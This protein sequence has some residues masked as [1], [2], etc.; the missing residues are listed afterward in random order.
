M[1]SFLAPLLSSDNNFC[2]EDYRADHDYCRVTIRLSWPAARR[3]VTLFAP[4]LHSVQSSVDLRTA[5]EIERERVR[6]RE[7]R[8]YRARQRE[9]RIIALRAL[10]CV[11]RDMIDYYQFSQMTEEGH[12]NGYRHSIFTS[13]SE[14]HFLYHEARRRCLLNLKKKGLSHS[15]IAKRLGMTKQAVSALLQK[16]PGKIPGWA[17]RKPRS[18]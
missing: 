14:R 15:Q 17:T 9:K 7:E 11:Y 16:K 2:I 4:F 18:F 3:M 10:K 5:R 12:P 13:G 8:I 1:N 6:Q